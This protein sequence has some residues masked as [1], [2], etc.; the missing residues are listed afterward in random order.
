MRTRLFI[1][2]LLIL[3]LASLALLKP[4]LLM[5]YLVTPITRILWLLL[6]LFLVVDQYLYWMLLVF[7]AFTILLKIASGHRQEAYYR[8]AYSDPLKKEDRVDYWETL[9]QASESDPQARLVLQQE[10]KNLQTM[11][12]SLGDENPPGEPHLPPKKNGGRVRRWVNWMKSLLL[13]WPSLRQKSRET[14]L[15]RRVAIIL[16]TM[17]ARLENN[18][19]R[20]SNPFFDD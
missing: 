14:D 10:L 1:P 5:A 17:E 12:T 16:D 13:R 7:M 8:T 19:V 3:L 18:D 9:L 15:Q 6:R 11:I 20:T 4:D 2:L